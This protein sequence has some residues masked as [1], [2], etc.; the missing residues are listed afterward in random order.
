[1]E[2][3]NIYKTGQNGVMKLQPHRYLRTHT[4]EYACSLSL[5]PHPLFPFHIILKQISGII[6]FHL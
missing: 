5:T 3:L 6:A 2:I 4:H 1:M